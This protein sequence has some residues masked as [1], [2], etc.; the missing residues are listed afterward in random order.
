MCYGGI[1]I[2]YIIKRTDTDQK[3]WLRTCDENEPA[4]SCIWTSTSL[5]A[6]IFTSESG[7]EDYI[8]KYLANRQV[9]PDKKII[10]PYAFA[11]GYAGGG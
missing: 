1:P 4:K 5:K 8:A 2:A 10:H 7:C 9:T 6:H 11:M 3:W